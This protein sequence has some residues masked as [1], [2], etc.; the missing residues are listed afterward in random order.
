MGREVCG[1]GTVSND[2]VCGIQLDVCDRQWLVPRQ[3]VSGDHTNGAPVVLDSDPARAV[4]V[5]ITARTYT[6]PRLILIL[7]V[8]SRL[9]IRNGR[10]F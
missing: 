8:A 6:G 4:L 2:R 1:G 10:P 5:T 9:L 7:N 3:C